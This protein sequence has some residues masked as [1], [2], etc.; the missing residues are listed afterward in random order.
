[1]TRYGLMA[2]SPRGAEDINTYACTATLMPR[3]ARVHRGTDA[4]IS[5]T[6]LPPDMTLDLCLA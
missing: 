6:L 3:I 2:K 5:C 4:N 1:M